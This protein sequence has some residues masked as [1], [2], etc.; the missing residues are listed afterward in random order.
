MCFGFVRKCF[1]ING[2]IILLMNK[3]LKT[4]NALEKAIKYLKTES[5]RYE[6]ERKVSL[7]NKDSEHAAYWYGK[8][9]GINEGVTALNV[10]L[11][12]LNNT[13]NDY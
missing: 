3:L 6:K 12:E 5:V 4:K 11:T 9:I 13:I 10:V 8:V 1:K 2:V 7:K